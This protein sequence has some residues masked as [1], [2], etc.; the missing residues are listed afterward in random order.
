MYIVFNTE[1]MRTLFMLCYAILDD[2]DYHK[3]V[4]VLLAGHLLPHHTVL[5]ILQHLASCYLIP[6]YV[7]MFYHAALYEVVVLGGIGCAH[8][9]V[10]STKNLRYIT[11]TMEYCISFYYN[12]SRSTC[13][14]MV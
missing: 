14:L 1:T 8:V 5:I 11:R 9:T 6:Y 3:L 4:V 2:I 12:G 10:Y 7:L 13:R